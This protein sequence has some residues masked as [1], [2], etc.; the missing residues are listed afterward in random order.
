MIHSKTLSD[1]M[2]DSKACN[3]LG[4]EPLVV[5]TVSI[6]DLG[7]VVL[8][9]RLVVV[10]RERKLRIMIENRPGGPR[11]SFNAFQCNVYVFTM[12]SLQCL[13]MS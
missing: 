5:V 3:D 7:M 10:R 12:S 1:N 2:I 6:P 8:V 4:R 9:G 11:M 13:T